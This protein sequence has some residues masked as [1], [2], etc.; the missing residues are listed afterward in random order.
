MF[1]KSIRFKITLWYI[2]ILALTL[3]LFS[4]L[5]YHNF[6]RSLY[7]N[8]DDLLQSKA[9]GIADSIDTYW[10]A[11]KL[12]AVT[13]GTKTSVF[14]KIN[15]INFVK[16][17]QHWVKEKSNDPKLMNTVVQIF[18]IKGKNIA[19]SKNIPGIVTIPKDIFDYVLGGSYT[20]DNF[21][22][23]SPGEKGKVLPLRAITIPVVE[24]DNVAYIVQVA[25]SLILA[26]SAL[27]NLKMRLFFLLP[28]IVCLTGI[29]GA[30]LAG[31]ALKPVDS[32]IRTARQITADNL[33]LRINIPD[34][35]DEIRRLADTFNDMITRLEESFHLEQQFIQD[36]SH[37]LK[38]PLTILKGELEITLKKIR[39]AQEYESVLNS[40]LDEINKISRL[41]E[42]LLILAR[43][44]NR[45]MPLETKPVDLNVLL[46]SLLG[47]IDILAKQ[48]NIKINF[49]EQEKIVLEADENQIRQVFLNL[50]DN[51]IKYTP[52]DGNIVLSLRKENNFAKIKISD[53]GISIPENALPYIFDRFY[54]VDKARSSLGFGL[55]LSIV[56]SIVDAHKGR[57]EVNAKLN[58]GTTFTVFFPLSRRFKAA[59]LSIGADGVGRDSALEGVRKN[60][61]ISRLIV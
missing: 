20:F 23:E 58:Q 45:E 1:L 19:S 10:E 40:S 52:Q 39:S 13:A 47:D 43:F 44:D 35:K 25:S 41:V 60:E 12:E 5:L 61:P 3:S 37:E 16:I 34:T 38:T 50:L 33:K 30:L 6:K 7:D 31:L 51:A 55:G 49:S 4:I 48:K 2:V 32:I 18:D 24:N 11:E 17:A 28:L 27:N 15:N 57:V 59:P 14:S 22:I 42:N 29:A 56:K 8:F 36:V 46:E 26:H 9:K 21:N 53:T 54:R